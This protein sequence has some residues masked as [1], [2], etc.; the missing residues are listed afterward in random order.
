RA[1]GGG[2]ARRGGEEGGPAVAGAHRPGPL[3]AG[4]GGL[5]DRRPLQTAGAPPLHVDLGVAQMA[6]EHRAQD[7]V[8]IAHG[9]TTS[10]SSRRSAGAVA[11]TGSF[12]P[13]LAHQPAPAG[14]ACEPMATTRVRRSAT[15]P[16]STQGPTVS[17]SAPR[18]KRRAYGRWRAN[19]PVRGSRAPRLASGRKSP[20]AA[21]VSRSASDASPGRI[22]RWLDR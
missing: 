11:Q 16:R 14:F 2:V 8:Q 19:S 22:S 5:G 21:P 15:R 10:T 1:A 4:G 9:A 17:A 6:L 13:P 7:L 3:L 18:R 20:S 12:C